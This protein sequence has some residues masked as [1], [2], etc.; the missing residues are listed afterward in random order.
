MEVQFLKFLE[1]IHSPILDK[2]MIFITSLGNGGI[3]WIALGLIV[4]F[5]KI[6]TQKRKP[7]V[8]F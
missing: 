1:A 3:F 2:V 6:R 8:F 5:Q 4:F 7:L